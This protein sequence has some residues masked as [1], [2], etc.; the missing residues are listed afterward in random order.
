VEEE[1]RILNVQRGS[2]GLNGNAD[3]VTRSTH[4]RCVKFG[5]LASRHATT[6]ARSS[7]AVAIL[8]VLL[9]WGGEVCRIRESHRCLG[10][11]HMEVIERGIMHSGIEML[12]TH[13][14]RPQAVCSE[15]LETLKVDA[16]YAS[17]QHHVKF[18]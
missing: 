8:G 13:N 12:A 2:R 17:Q 11:E 3:I 4:V 14:T 16:K 1:D 18:K 5:L 6:I 7:H 9:A 15:A 10:N